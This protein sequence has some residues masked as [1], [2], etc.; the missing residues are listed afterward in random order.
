MT[1][2]ARVSRKKTEY[3]HTA[4]LDAMIKGVQEKKA[5]NITVMD[6]RN[7]D[8]APADFFIVC[9]GDSGTQVEAIARSIE[10]QVEKD[11]GEQPA[12]IEGTK[13]AQWV[14]IDYI[15]VVAHIFQPEQRDY[16]GLEHLWGD[17]VITVLNENQNDSPVFNR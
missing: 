1:K 5:R 14:L 16:Y 12:H 4:L 3:A 6:L 15:A 8:G 9:S 7:L 10:E 17:A 13:N 11:C 2:A